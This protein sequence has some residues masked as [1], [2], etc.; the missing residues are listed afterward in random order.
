MGKFKKQPQQKRFRPK[1]HVK[2][3]DTVV[4]LSGES[5]GEEGRVLKVFYRTGKAIVEGVNIVTKHAKQSAENPQG[6]I[7]KQEAPIYL[8]KLMVVDKSGQPSRVGRRREGNKIV[9]YA[10][11][12]GQILD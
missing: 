12:S 9:R 8:S 6:G 5:K 3:G 11:K 7:L 1:F 4:V 2:K 10:K